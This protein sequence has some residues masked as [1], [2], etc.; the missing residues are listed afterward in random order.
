MN[1][2]QKLT[3]NLLFLIVVGQNLVAMPPKVGPTLNAISLGGSQ[4]LVRMHID[5]NAIGTRA[6]TTLPD[7]NDRSAY[8]TS[9]PETR[10]EISL[11]VEKQIDSIGRE[12]A[13]ML[14]LRN[15]ALSLRS[16]N[17]PSILE[18]IGKDIVLCNATI[19]ELNEVKNSFLNSI[20]CSDLALII[21]S[22]VNDFSAKHKDNMD[23]FNSLNGATGFSSNPHG[24]DAKFKT[25]NGLAQ[26][27][28]MNKERERLQQPQAPKTPEEIASEIA[29]WEKSTKELEAFLAEEEQKTA[30]PSRAPKSKKGK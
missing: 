13:E 23:T 10:E 7:R 19:N 4:G 26:K 1:S 20:A 6:V 24:D 14:T 22:I 16:G 11:L 5:L 29:E 2:I 27:A 9:I 12:K 30:K 17:K 25:K 3:K 18:V 8:L 28:A 15:Q 21:H